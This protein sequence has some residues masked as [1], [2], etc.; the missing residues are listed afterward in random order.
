MK[1]VYFESGDIVEFSSTT[2]R[3]SRRAII[4][5]IRSI[6]G[7]GNIAP[8]Y[9]FSRPWAREEVRPALRWW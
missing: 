7:L 3:A 8:R 5:S 9:R 6:C 2:T 1:T 4:R